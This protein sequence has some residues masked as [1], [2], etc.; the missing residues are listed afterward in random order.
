MYLSITDE[1]TGFTVPHVT[2][3]SFNKNV[4]QSHGHESRSTSTVLDINEIQD[5]DSLKNSIKTIWQL[6]LMILAVLVFLALV[7]LGKCVRRQFTSRTHQVGLTNTATPN[8]MLNENNQIEGWYEQIQDA[9][10]EDS[11]RYLTPACNESGTL[12]PH[13][14]Q[15]TIKEQI[16]LVSI[17]LMPGPSND[18]VQ[19]GEKASDKNDIYENTVKEYDDLYISPCV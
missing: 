17:A 9:E 6:M 2:L 4:N 1:E 10:H 11:G 5:E 12:G 15:E 7:Y 18:N 3:T 19:K 16:E 13:P 8:V 14:N